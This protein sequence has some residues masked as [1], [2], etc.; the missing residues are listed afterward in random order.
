MN[1]DVSSL[2]DVVDPSGRPGERHDGRDV[3]R[4]P[5]LLVAP[6]QEETTRKLGDR[7]T[8]GRIRSR[9]RTIDRQGRGGYTED[10]LGQTGRLFGWEGGDDEWR[11][12]GR[13]GGGCGG[14]KENRKG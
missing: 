12:F 4:R 8:H 7:L 14:W 5:W 10:G 6:W 13:G 3:I 1:P 2:Q 9:H 11:E